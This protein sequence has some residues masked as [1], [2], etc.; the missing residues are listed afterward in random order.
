MGKMAMGKGNTAPAAASP[1]WFSESRRLYAVKP[2]LLAD[3]GE[4]ELH[5]QRWC[6]NMTIGRL[7]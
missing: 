5:W 3:I 6:E 1:R 4:G 2:V 7:C